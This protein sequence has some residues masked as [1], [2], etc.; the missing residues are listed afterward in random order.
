MYW[1]LT[2]SLYAMAQ[3]RKMT[4][5]QQK[6]M[7]CRRTRPLRARPHMS[8]AAS[9]GAAPCRQAQEQTRQ[10]VWHAARGR[11]HPHLV[12]C[13]RGKVVADLRSQTDRMSD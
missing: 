4:N 6:P 10:Q 5:T 1:G 9:T 8:A 13:E 11:A 7:I 3:T 12:N 2:R